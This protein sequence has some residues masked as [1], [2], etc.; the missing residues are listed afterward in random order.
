M[1]TNELLKSLKACEDAVLW[2]GDKTIEE[3]V[4]T[5]HRGDWL[6]WLAKKLDIGKSTIY[7]FIQEGKIKLPK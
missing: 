5:C 1:E 6:L 7:R 4:D 3:I 2:A